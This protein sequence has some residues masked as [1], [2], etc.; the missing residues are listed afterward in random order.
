MN[1][2]KAAAEVKALR[3]LAEMAWIIIANAHGGN[4]KAP[5]GAGKK[6]DKNWRAAAAKWRDDYHASLKR[7]TTE[8]P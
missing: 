2:K 6:F 7:M 5:T 4:W 1:A 3:D 8:K